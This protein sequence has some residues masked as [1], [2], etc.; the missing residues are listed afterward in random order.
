MSS[1]I[2]Y[3]HVL[4]FQ[5]LNILFCMTLLFYITQS[6]GISIFLGLVSSFL[7]LEIILRVSKERHNFKGLKKNENYNDQFIESHPHL[8]FI[9]KKGVFIPMLPKEEYEYMGEECIF[10]RIKTNK[11]GHL[12]GPMGNRDVPLHNDVNTLR[13]SCLGDSVAANYVQNNGI[14][15]NFSVEIER[16]LIGKNLKKNVEVN[17]C[18]IGGYSTLDILVKFLIKDIHEK[19][20]IIILNHGYSNI[21]SFLC[22]NYEPDHSHFRKSFAVGERRFKAARWIPFKK[23]Y[24]FSLFFSPFLPTNLKDFLKYVSVSNIN[25]DNDWKGLNFFEKNLENMIYLAKSNNITVVFC[26]CPHFLHDDI[27]DH[28][29]HKKFHEGMVLQ[30]NIIRK[31]AKKHS[32]LLSDNENMLEKCPQNFIDS[33]HLAPEGIEKCASNVV[34]T[35]LRDIKIKKLLVSQ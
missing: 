22:E 27:Y 8:P 5:F 14:N 13:I 28:P 12:N 29:G 7:L 32:V 34:D 11:Q 17:N 2:R 21:R 25:I 23:L 35:I 16:Q 15:Y 10:P 1:K 6:W 4:C 30:N 19:P 31:V 24:I 33:I 18:A 20:Q 26:T 9:Y 3:R